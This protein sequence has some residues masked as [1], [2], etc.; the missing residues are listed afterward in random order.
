MSKLLITTQVY[1]NYAWDENGN[2]GK[3]AD[4]YWKA[5]GGS[6]YVVKNFRDYNRARRPHFFTGATYASDEITERFMTR[7]QIEEYNAGYDFNEQFGDKKQ[8]Y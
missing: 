5:K 1:E 3:G 2:L 8:W 6:D 7:A 4:A